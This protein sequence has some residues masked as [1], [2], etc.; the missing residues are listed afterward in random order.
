MRAREVLT[1]II[2]N[3]ATPRKSRGALA[4]LQR[5]VE[6]ERSGYAPT[7][8]SSWM[9]NGRRTHETMSKRGR[10]VT[11]VENPWN[12]SANTLPLDRTHVYTRSLDVYN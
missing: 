4:K 5:E 9:T 3:T 8:T 11:S 10:E 2:I 12:E 6:T 1:S 7:A